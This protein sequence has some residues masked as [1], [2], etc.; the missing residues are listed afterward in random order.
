MHQ[1][2]QQREFSEHNLW[3]RIDA[4][5]A[6]AGAAHAPTPTSTLPVDWPA[7]DA[8]LCVIA[9][10][11]SGNCSALLMKDRK[12][13]V[14]RVCLIDAGISPRRVSMFLR[15]QGLKPHDVTDVLFTHLDRDHC[16]PG[17]VRGLPG[18]ARF[19]V[20]RSHLSRA[21]REGLAERE[22]TPFD[23]GPSGSFTLTRGVRVSAV[24]LAHDELGVAAFRVECTSGTLGFATDL[25]R[26]REELIDH[27]AGVDVLAIESNYCPIL[28]ANSARP[29][30]LKQ[31]ITGGSGHLSNQESAEAV[32]RIAPKQHAVLLHLSRE[33]NHPSLAISPHLD[34][35]YTVTISDQF[36][37]TPWVP[38]GTPQDPPPTP[39]KQQQ[40]ATANGSSLAPPSPTTFRPATRARRHGTR[41]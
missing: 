28:Q 9:S 24:Q 34:A 18:H 22:L 15:H 5:S 13:G 10:G 1:Q 6:S 25:G 29:Y 11:S 38:I 26:V 12:T 37:P 3:N 7:V 17:W 16:H 32:A 30:F 33:C 35:P 20:L 31:R 27:L 21:R 41:A 4:I 19:R 2:H 36:T 23:A 40:P 14:S 39:R 8:T